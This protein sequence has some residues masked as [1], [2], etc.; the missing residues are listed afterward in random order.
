MGKNQEQIQALKS[1]WTET[2]QVILKRRSVRLYKKEQVPEF[3]VNRILEAGRCRLSAERRP[4]LPGAKTLN[5]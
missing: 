1:T 2:E 3:M 4:P 5:A